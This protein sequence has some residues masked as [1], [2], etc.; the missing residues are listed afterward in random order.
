MPMTPMLKVSSGTVRDPE[1][2]RSPRRMFVAKIVVEFGQELVAT[3]L[4]GTL[5]ET[6]QWV[7][8][9]IAQKI[10]HELTFLIGLSI[11]W[12]C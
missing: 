7:R 2:D 6:E 8:F 9:C 12:A 4:S 11:S 5:L 10:L 1:C 3:R